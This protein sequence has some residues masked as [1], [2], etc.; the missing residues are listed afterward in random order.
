MEANTRTQGRCKRQ[1]RQLRTLDPP[2]KRI[3]APDLWHPVLL[4]CVTAELSRTRKSWCPNP[5]LLCT[6]QTQPLSSLTLYRTRPPASSCKGNQLTIDSTDSSA[7]LF[8]Y[9]T[10]FLKFWLHGYLRLKL[11]KFSHGN[12]DFWSLLKLEELGT[13]S[14]A[15]RW[16][17][18]LGLRA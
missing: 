11:W 3:H 9:S 18:S 12:L 14:W 6:L 8:P 7:A 17:H 13:P 1:G 10:L 15:L 16:T 5:H 4:G 2:R